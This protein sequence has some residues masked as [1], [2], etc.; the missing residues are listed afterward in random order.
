MVSVLGELGLAEL[1]ASIHGMSALSAAVILAETGDRA[2]PVQ[3]RP[4]RG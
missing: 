4:R 1:A 3:L 2:A